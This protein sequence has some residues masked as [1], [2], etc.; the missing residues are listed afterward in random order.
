MKKLTTEEFIERAK[1]IHGNKYDYSKVM[2][3]SMHEKV[4]IICPEHEEFLKDASSHLKGQGCPKCS[5]KEM[6]VNKLSNTNS[7]IEKAR[8]IHGDK[9]DYSKVKYI[10]NQTR[11]CIIC[12][13]HGEFWQIPNNHLNGS[14][15]LECGKKNTWDKR[16]RITTKEFI[17]KAKKIHGDK[18]DYSKAKYINNITPICIICSVHGEF[19]QTPIHHLRGC[20]CP[21]CSKIN[22]SL[23][24]RLN[25]N[26]FIE[27]AKKVHGDKYDYS[28]VKYTTTNEKVCIVCSEH[29]KFWQEASSHLRGCGCPVCK[30]SKLEKLTRETLLNSDIEFIEHCNKKILKWLEKQ[31]LD[32]YLPKYNIGIECQGI[33]HYKRDT[34]F[35]KNGKFDD[36]KKRDKKKKILCKENGVKLIYIQYNMSDEQITKKISQ[37]KG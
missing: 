24:Q 19:W 21:K 36:I 4:C 8:K 27:K 26:D 33:Q 10:N 3:K 23:K 12:P 6:S 16:G 18:Y 7:F 17:E 22:G 35:G 37:I 20:D 31:H 9:Y 29:G 2:Y 1:K 32:F 30:E 25:T 14:G 28:K 34:L 11:V 13:E 15:C 5:F